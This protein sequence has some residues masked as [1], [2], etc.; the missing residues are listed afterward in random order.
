VR[1]SRSRLRSMVGGFLEIWLPV[2]L[3]I[4]ALALLIFYLLWW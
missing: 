1:S 3:P 2:L 4:L